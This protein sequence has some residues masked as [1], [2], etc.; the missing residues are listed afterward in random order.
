MELSKTSSASPAVSLETLSAQVKEL[1]EAFNQNTGVY[2]AAFESIDA[3]LAVLFQLANDLFAGQAKTKQT[4]SGVGIDFQAY[5][6]EYRA[7]YEETLKHQ[8]ECAPDA[9][10]EDD[11]VVVFGGSK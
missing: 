11:S 5:F 3:R 9:A 6:D 10:E 4:E 2:I 7:R 8:E 1:G